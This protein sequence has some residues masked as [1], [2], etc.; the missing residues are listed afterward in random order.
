MTRGGLVSSRDGHEAAGDF[1]WG[2]THINERGQRIAAAL[3]I[4]RL[5]EALSEASSSTFD[6]TSSSSSTSAATATSAA[7]SASTV[8]TSAAT[9]TSTT[10][11]VDNAAVVDSAAAPSTTAASAASTTPALPSPMFGTRRR[12]QWQRIVRG[13]PNATE[14]GNYEANTQ[15]CFFGAALNRSIAA[16]GR[17]A[18]GSPGWRYVTEVSLRGAAK[19]G[20]VSLVPGSTLTL[21][22][23]SPWPRAALATGNAR[24]P[25]AEESGGAALHVAFL[26]SYSARMGRAAVRCGGGCNCTEGLLDG[27]QPSEGACKQCSGSVT[28]VAS[29]RLWPTA[30]HARPK[31]SGTEA[32]SGGVGMQSAAEHSGGAGE[33]RGELSAPREDECVVSIVHLPASVA[34]SGKVRATSKARAAAAAVGDGTS[35]WKLLGVVV[36]AQAVGRVVQGTVLGWQ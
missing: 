8:T 12:A 17:A 5:S 36:G 11:T 30:S 33:P 4:R 22:L 16:E 3:V 23:P 7:T 18:E 26:R 20:L 10:A 15:R 6:A 35:K 13:S 34:A 29:M 2:G 24:A 21:R 28:H 27:Q 32:A 9:S 19:P 25:E 1:I 31:A 14:P